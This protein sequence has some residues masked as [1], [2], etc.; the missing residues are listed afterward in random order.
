M[1]LSAGRK[2]DPE[3]ELLDVYARMDLPGEDAATAVSDRNRRERVRA[4]I[5]VALDA[6]MANPRR[7]YGW[8]VQAMFEAVVIALGSVKLIK[9]EDSGVYFHDDEEGDIKVPDFRIVKANGEILLVEVKGVAPKEQLKDRKLSKDYIDALRR[10]ATLNGARIMFAHYWSA[11]NVWTLVDVE[12]FQSVRKSTDVFLSFE[13]AFMLN[14]FGSLGDAMIGTTPPLVV[15]VRSASN[16]QSSEELDADAMKLGVEINGFLDIVAGGK[17][18]TDQ[19]EKRIALF[20]AMYGGWTV[21]PED[22]TMDGGVAGKTITLTPPVEGAEDIARIAQQGFA[23]LRFLSAMYSEM[24]NQ[25]TLTKEGDVR[26]LRQEPNPGALSRLIPQNYW[27]KVD[28]AL[29][30][31]KLQIEV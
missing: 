25:V 2:F 1:V 11:M 23:V 28:R 16:S 15:T 18:I 31:W 21:S 20:A 4:Q 30:V 17:A 8:R 6:S 22:L 29:R 27:D 19:T 9:Q 10:Y 12:G 13:K 14:E 7:L 24:Y 26:S 3:L 5:E